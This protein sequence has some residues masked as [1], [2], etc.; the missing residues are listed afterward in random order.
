MQDY[1]AF[2]IGVDGHV[3]SRIDLWCTDVADAKERAKKPVD[4][5]DIEL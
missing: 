5:H 1:R 2:V 4:G 3:K